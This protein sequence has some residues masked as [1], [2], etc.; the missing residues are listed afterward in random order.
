MLGKNFSRQCYE[1]CFLVCSP[2][3]TGVGILCKSSPNGIVCTKYHTLFSGKYK[4]KIISLSSGEF[5]QRAK[6]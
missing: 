4:E 2:K 3:K 1:I 6:G 5:A